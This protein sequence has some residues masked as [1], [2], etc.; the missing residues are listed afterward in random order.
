LQYL[1]EQARATPSRTLLVGDSAVDH[2]TAVRAGVRCCLATYGFGYVSF[3]AE[4]LSGN[5]WLVRHPSELVP[6]FEAMRY[7]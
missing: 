1:I 3:P 6:I 7:Q 2:E 5:E 4:R